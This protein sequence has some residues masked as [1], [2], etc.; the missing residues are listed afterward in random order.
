MTLLSVTTITLAGLVC[1][2]LLF[3]LLVIRNMFIPTR[4]KR[5]SSYAHPTRALLVMDI[6]ESSSSR[7]IPKRPLSAAT[8]FGRMIESVNQ[9][10][11]GFDHYGLEVAYVRQVFSCNLIT[12]LHGGRILAGRMEP[13]ISRWVKI[14]NSNDFA[15][16]RTDAFSN[17]QLEQFLVDHQVDEIFL[18][19]LDAAFCVYYTALGA[20][21]RGYRVTVVS[22]AVM[23]G[24]NMS[25]VLERYHSKG[26]AVLN[27]QEVVAAIDRGAFCNRKEEMLC[28][29]AN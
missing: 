10:I 14:V 21:N 6:Q 5:I 24:K 27:S 19:G 28:R 17:R 22:D 12:R 11:E 29:S 8:P 23:T 26:I 16:N 25:R 20:L 7:N 18:V 13:R 3:A 1:L 15:K 4:G 9:V 2:V